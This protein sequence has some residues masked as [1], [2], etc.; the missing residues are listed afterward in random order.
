MP[1]VLGVLLAPYETFF[2]QSNIAIGDYIPK[3]TPSFEPV[4]NF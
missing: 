1:Q 2:I 3:D 4:N